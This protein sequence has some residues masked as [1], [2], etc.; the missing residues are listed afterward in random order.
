MASWRLYG[1]AEG[2]QER[3]GAPMWPTYRDEYEQEVERV[4]AMLEASTLAAA[5]QTGRD[6][7]DEAMV[8]EA[9]EAA[10]FLSSDDP[11]TSEPISPET[12]GLTARELDVLRLLAT[13][14]SNQ[15]IA[16][17]LFISITTVKGHVQHIMRKLGLS[18]RTALAA[19][20]VRS[21]LS[22]AEEG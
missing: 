15:E 5:W 12:Y 7:S 18:S 19:F 9:L 20:A 21:H 22:A 13:G 2:L 1:I 8:A 16:D 17:T 10:A 14:A 3:L 4:R 11:A 6:L